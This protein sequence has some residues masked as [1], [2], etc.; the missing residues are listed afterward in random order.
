[1]TQDSEGIVVIQLVTDEMD[2]NLLKITSSHVN[3]KTL[4]FLCWGRGGEG[5]KETPIVTCLV[6]SAAFYLRE[7]ILRFNRFPPTFKS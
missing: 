4:I 2:S 5:S 1:M 7:V 6:E 3:K